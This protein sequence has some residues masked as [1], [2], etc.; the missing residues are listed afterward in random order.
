MKPGRAESAWL[1]QPPGTGCEPVVLIGFMGSGKT[2]VGQELARQCESRFIDTDAVLTEQFGKPVVRIFRED[3]ETAFRSAEATLLRQL[4]SQSANLAAASDRH[5]RPS[6]V[7]ATGGG[8]CTNL[9]TCALLLRSAIVVWLHAD[10]PEIKRR[11]GSDTNRPLLAGNIDQLYESRQSS[12]ASCAHF[13]VDAFLP[14]GQV[15]ENILRLLSGFGHYPDL[16]S[17]QFGTG[18][19][20]VDA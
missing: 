8:A 5:C 17:G 16:I 19:S 12:Y 9:E 10:L 1:R 14:P 11:V 6:L 4:C 20:L 7:I 18:D 2:T 13:Q 15:V 3:G